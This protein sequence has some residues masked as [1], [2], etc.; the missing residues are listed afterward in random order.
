MEEYLDRYLKPEES[1]HHLDMNTE[2]NRIGNLMLF[3]SHAEHRRYEM[4]GQKTGKKDM[5]GRICLLC[6]SRKTHV[7][8]KGHQY[9]CKFENGFVCL[10]CYMREHR[11]R[12]ERIL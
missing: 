11:K 3:A 8:K 1:V 10:K 5:S 9:W 12:G 4:L 7:D 6:D 2:N